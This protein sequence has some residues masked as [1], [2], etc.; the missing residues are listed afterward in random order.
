MEKNENE[1]EVKATQAVENSESVE[2]KDVVTP[3]MEFDDTEDEKKIAYAKNLQE[4]KIFFTNCLI[5]N[6]TK[7]VFAIICF[8]FTQKTGVIGTFLFIIAL[9][10]FLPIGVIR[11][12]VYAHRLIHVKDYVSF[13]NDFVAVDLFHFMH[14]H[15]KRKGE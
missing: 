12:I 10:Y 2:A 6:I 11:T 14:S 5:S 15:L 13:D 1:T 8:I 3:I 7:I 4:K 9:F